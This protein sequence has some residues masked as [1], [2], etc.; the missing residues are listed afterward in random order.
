MD[1]EQPDQPRLTL[2]TGRLR[3]REVFVQTVRDAL[4]CAASE[5]WKET[6]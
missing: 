4:A 2:P 6:P 3:G 5:G 1:S